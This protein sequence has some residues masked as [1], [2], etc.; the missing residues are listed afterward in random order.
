MIDVAFNVEH[1]HLFDP[2]TEAS[3]TDGKE[4]VAAP[5]PAGTAGETA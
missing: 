4:P 5:E 3:L 2:E 1:L